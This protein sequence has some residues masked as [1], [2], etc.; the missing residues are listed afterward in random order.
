MPERQ[1]NPALFERGLFIVGAQ[2]AMFV[3]LGGGI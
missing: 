3:I 2:V 1:V